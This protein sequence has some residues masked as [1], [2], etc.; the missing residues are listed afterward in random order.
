MDLAVL[1]VAGS[2]TESVLVDTAGVVAGGKG[3]V[4]ELVLVEALDVDGVLRLVV[5][6]RG[7]PENQE[8]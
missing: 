3:G 4:V 8:T 7:V 2:L 5:R 6:V 1:L